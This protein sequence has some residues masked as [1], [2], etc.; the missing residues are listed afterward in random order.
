M[1]FPAGRFY[2]RG[3]PRVVLAFDTVSPAPSVAAHG[4]SS[5]TPITVRVTGGAESLPAV[6]TDVLNRAGVQLRDVKEV[7]VVSGPG[8]FT[9]LRA[10]VAFARGLARGLAAP[11]RL[12]PTF[13]AAAS[14]YPAPASADFLLGAGRGEVHRARRRVVS[15]VED[16]TPVP[17]EEALAAAAED[18]A[19]TVDLDR[20]HLPLAAAAAWI[21]ASGAEFDEGMRYGRPSAAEEKRAASRGPGPG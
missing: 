18:G 11:V 4:G 14:A 13:V 16:Q 17:I 2:H 15:L 9:G 6:L 5:P 19:T 10:G 8:S 20:E 3:M 7:A 1:T 21:V 12:V